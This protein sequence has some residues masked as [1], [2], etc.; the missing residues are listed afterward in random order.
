M[1]GPAGIEKY[2]LSACNRLS[3]FHRQCG[4]ANTFSG[5]SVISVD[6]YTE[7]TPSAQTLI[8]S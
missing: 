4:N 1:V 5:F 7:N 2:H 8:H 3:L 6:D